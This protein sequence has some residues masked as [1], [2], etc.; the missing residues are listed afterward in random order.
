MPEHVDKVRTQPCKLCGKPITVEMITKEYVYSEYVGK[1]GECF[2]C[3]ARLRKK[4][5]HGDL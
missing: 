2:K 1:Q 3:A 5:K 4:R